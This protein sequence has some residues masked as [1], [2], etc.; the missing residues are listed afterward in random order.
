MTDVAQGYLQSLSTL[1]E[2]NPA[3]VDL[4]DKR[5]RE[6]LS[7]KGADGKPTAKPIWQFEQDLRKDPEWMS[8]QNA[9]DTF[10]QA[11]QAILKDFGFGW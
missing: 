8:T 9:Q 7:A 5:I 3:E 2:K 1:L 10:G 6:A 4:Y 11:T